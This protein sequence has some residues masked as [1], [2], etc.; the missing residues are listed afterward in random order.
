MRYG[1]RYGN[2]LGCVRTTSLRAISTLE[3]FLFSSSMD[4]RVFGYVV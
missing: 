2:D 3:M 1:V 4:E